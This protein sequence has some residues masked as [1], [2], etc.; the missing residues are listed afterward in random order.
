MSQNDFRATKINSD[1]KETWFTRKNI[2]IIASIAGFIVIL[3]ILALSGVNLGEVFIQWTLNYET[4][5]GPLGIYLAIFLIS[6]F[7]NLTVLFPVPYI[8]ALS[9]II[10]TMGIN[11][12]LLGFVAG[13][14]AALGEVTA[15][16]LGKGS[17]VLIESGTEESEKAKKMKDRINRGWAI[18]LMLLFAATPIPDDPLLLMLGYAN[19]SIWKMLI[20][21]FVGKVIICLG[22]AYLILFAWDVPAFGFVF[23][24]LGIDKQAIIEY[25][26]TGHYQSSIN[27]WISFAAWVGL[28]MFI[29]LLFYVD[30]SKQFKKL[31]KRQEKD[32]EAKKGVE[33]N[34][35]SFGGKSI[36]LQRMYRK[37]L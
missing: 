7:A 12:L 13:A 25:E 32:I 19:Y 30:W 4:K 11:P 29:F 18:P 21:Y 27:P 31:F 22:T 3:L 1:E 20:T 9:I 17:A 28:L 36:L 34:L 33:V 14:G 26:S 24:L 10:F 6:I 35:I 16:Y 37:Y 15:Y 8:I 5:F 2:I 23:S